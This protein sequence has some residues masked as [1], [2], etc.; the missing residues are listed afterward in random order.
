VI[1]KTGTITAPGCWHQ[2]EGTGRKRQTCRPACVR[3]LG[4]AENV[5]CELPMKILNRDSLL[6][7]ISI[8]AVVIIV[9]LGVM[10]YRAYCAMLAAREYVSDV[11][12]IQIAITGSREFDKIRN[13][14]KQFAQANPTCNDQD[15]NVSFHF[16]NGWPGGI[17]LAHAAFIY[18]GLT[19]FH[20]SITSI[21]IRSSCYGNNGGE[22]VATMSES[23]PNEAHDVPF[24][25]GRVMSSD[26]V[27]TISFNLNAT[28]SP[29]QRGHAYAF[30][31]NFLS[32]FGACNDATDMH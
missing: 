23:L 25:E 29:E 1:F 16:T 6:K 21:D 10:Y 24:R 9:T 14:Y 13:R 5:K 17:H 11:S 19:L 27:A 7:L 28:A 4:D 20:G 18:S 22:F 30:N 8:F 32:R 12:R 2:N 15:C 31:E 3:K 26:K